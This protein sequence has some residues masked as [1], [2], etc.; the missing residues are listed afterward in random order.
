MLVASMHV[1]VGITKV[2]LAQA[3]VLSVQLD[4][5]KRWTRGKEGLHHQG[6]S[7]ALQL[8]TVTC[9]EV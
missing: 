4:L 7:L 8:S 9:G 5:C 1:G 6:V 3:A 2:L